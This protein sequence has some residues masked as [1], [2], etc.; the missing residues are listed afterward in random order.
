M[1]AIV[2]ATDNWMIEI[3]AWLICWNLALDLI[4]INFARIAFASVSCDIPFGLCDCKQSYVCSLF[5]D[6]AGPVLGLWHC[7]LCHCAHLPALAVHLPALA[8]EWALCDQCM[9]TVGIPCVRVECSLDR[10][11]ITKGNTVVIPTRLHDQSVSKDL[12]WSPLC[13]CRCLCLA[14]LTLRLP[15]FSSHLS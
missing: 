1:S 12:S 11:A 6:L 14:L 2:R 10:H 5:Y 15:P 9:S 13:L 8:E 7:S 3:S 4:L